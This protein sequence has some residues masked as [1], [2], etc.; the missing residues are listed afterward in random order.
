MSI[1][2]S[3]RDK[4]LINKLCHAFVISDIWQKIFKP[5][6]SQEQLAEIAAGKSQSLVD[7]YFDKEPD[8][9]AIWQALQKEMPKVHKAL[10]KDLLKMKRDHNDR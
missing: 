5:T 7:Y 8:V 4:M 3:A 10:A 1:R 6:L 2:I 9:K